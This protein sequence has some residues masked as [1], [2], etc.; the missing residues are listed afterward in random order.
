MMYN[1]H[2]NGAKNHEK[3]RDYFTKKNLQ[4]QCNYCI[5]K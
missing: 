4:S 1:M 2:K 5:I 3:F